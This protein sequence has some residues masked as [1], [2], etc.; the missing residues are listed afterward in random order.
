MHL[1][2]ILLIFIRNPRLGKVKTRLARTAGDA[3]AL[4][5][6][7]ILLERTRRAALGVRVER[8]LCYSDFIDKNDDWPEADFSKKMQAGSDLGAR[9]EQA[10]RTA[11]EAGANKVVI[12][13][14]DCPKLRGEILQSAFNQLDEFDFVLGPV[15][16][17]GYYL[18]GMKA[19]EPSVFQDVEW[20]TSK[21]RAQTLEKITAAGKSCALLPL[22]PD[23]DT[24]DD[25]L[26]VQ[27][28]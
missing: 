26:A 12:I 14:S 23:V 22:L 3:E 18:L 11:F 15:P 20:S 19:L 21:V 1:H 6:Y 17:G 4:R 13:G 9:M 10:F 16:D 27:P 24:E 2:E 8:W 28:L 7:R 25:W 5:I